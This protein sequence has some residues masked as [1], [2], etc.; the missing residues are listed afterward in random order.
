MTTTLNITKLECVKKRDPIGKDEIDIYVS[1][2][3]GSDVFLSGPHFLDKSKNDDEVT[4]NGTKAFE[5]KIRIRLKER[6]GTRGGNNDLDLG[7]EYVYQDE[8]HNKTYT[9]PFSAN[10]GGVVYNLSYKLTS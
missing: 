4:L 10:N 8:K 9:V 3:G 7:T 2:D 6:N 5:T 1:V